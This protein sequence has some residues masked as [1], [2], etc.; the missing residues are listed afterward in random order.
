MFTDFEKSFFPTDDEIKK[1]QDSFDKYYNWIKDGYMKQGMSERQ[2][3][4]K[5]SE[6]AE[7]YS[8]RGKYE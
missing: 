6:D 5:M 2:A 7:D 4:R 8:K 1:Q 3:E